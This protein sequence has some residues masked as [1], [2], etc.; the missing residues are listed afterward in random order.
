MPDNPRNALI[1]VWSGDLLTNYGNVVVAEVLRRRVETLIP[2][3]TGAG[4]H[5]AYRRDFPGA[6]LIDAA[7]AIGNIAVAFQRGHTY[8]VTIAETDEYLWTPVAANMAAGDYW[9]IELVPTVE[10]FRACAVPD[11]EII[12]EAHQ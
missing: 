11:S 6:V 9:A 12:R 1:R 2:G 3:R 8:R 7:D 4:A 10:Y 5:A